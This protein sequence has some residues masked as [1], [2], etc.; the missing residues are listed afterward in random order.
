MRR[1]VGVRTMLGVF[2]LAACLA[3]AARAQ[4]TVAPADRAAIQHVIT[5][6]I[7]AFRHDD[8]TAAFG[9]AAPRIRAMFGDAPHFLAMV[10]D[11]Y[12]PVYR[13]RSV[14]FGTLTRQDGSLVQ[15]VELVGPDGQGALAQG[16]LALYVMEHEPDGNWRIAGCSLVKSERQEI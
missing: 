3:G 5:A 1:M 8:G 4:D 9:F 15:K 14:S 12:P 13:P 11:A 16:V 10:R 7:E 6:Q 2:L